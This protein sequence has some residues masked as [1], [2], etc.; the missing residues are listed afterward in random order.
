M[1]GAFRLTRNS[2]AVTGKMD[3][4]IS[5]AVHAAMAKEVRLAASDNTG[6]DVVQ[7]QAKAMET[8]Q[9]PADLLPQGSAS[10]NRGKG[11]RKGENRATGEGASLMENAM[12]KS[13]H[14][15]SD[16]RCQAASEDARPTKKAVT[17]TKRT[18]KKMQS[19]VDSN[20]MALK[21]SMG[22]SAVTKKRPRRFKPES[23][24]STKEP[25]GQKRDDQ[26]D[27]V[28]P[29]PQLSQFVRGAVRTTQVKPTKLVA[30][31]CE[32]VGVGDK[33]R[34]DA[35]ARASLVN[36]RGEVLFDSFV[37][38]DRPVVDYR[39]EVS[40]VLPEHLRGPNAM[41]PR[42]AQKKVAELL[43][44]RL[45]VGHAVGNDL[46]VLR[47]NHPRGD[48]RDTAEYFKRLWHKSGRRGKH[49][50][51]LRIVVAKVLGVDQFQTHEH[52]SREDARAALA[53]YKKVAKEWEASRRRG[54]MS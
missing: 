11:K 30:L 12:A 49:P 24:G 43:K 51:G 26:K 21:R 10:A 15:A 7:S 33:G 22:A 52:D 35:L 5:E 28:V 37:R 23:N 53:V 18:P 39:T 1:R 44:G 36:S 38:V 48:T 54:A 19:A 14:D 3:A 42:A 2:V 4:F 50:P 8:D 29:P 45:L 41:D 25:V 6:G 9:R 31:D 20:W 47:I 46:R 16:P 27:S 32:F 13:G 40:G 17:S 34:E